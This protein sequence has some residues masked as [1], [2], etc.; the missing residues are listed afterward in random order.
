MIS[1][2]YPADLADWRGLFIRHMVD[3]LARRMDVDLRVWS[4]PGEFPGNA[5]YVAS[6][7]EARWLAGLMRA[8]GI[9]HLMRTGGLRGLDAPLRLLGMLRDLYRREFSVDLYHVNWLQNALALPRNNLPLLTTVLGTDM[10]LLKLPGMTH[11]LRRVF[12]RR[13]TAICP[14]AQWML[15]ELHRRFGD[16]AGIRFVPFG[17]EP[18]WFHVERR[19]EGPSKWLCVSRLTQGKIGTLFEWCEP[20][21]SAGRRELHLFGPMQET[22][23]VPPWV[24]YHGAAT[25]ESL[26]AE[27]FPKA[28]GLITLSRHAEG[29]PQVMLEAMAA[30]LPVIASRIPAH[31]DLLQH[32]ETGWLC[33]DAEGVGAALETLDELSTS[34][35]LGLRA[36]AWVQQNIGTW[37]DC[38]ARYFNVYA[39]L[40]SPCP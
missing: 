20:F 29:R 2:S 31:E 27:W 9:A 33:G 17:I 12:R 6:S 26:C 16:L 14:N 37:D 36:K 8:G 35:E 4:P 34:T 18:R 24:R 30:G 7:G 23:K 25:P 11:M 38:A 15:P 13:R 28:N 32:E 21:F 22:M 1:T 10:Q 40:V 19:P 5:K 39:D 3:A